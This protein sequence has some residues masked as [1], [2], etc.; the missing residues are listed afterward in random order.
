MASTLRF[1]VGP[2]F[3]CEASVMAW[4]G[5]E[6]VTLTCRLTANP[7]VDAKTVAWRFSRP[8]TN[9]TVEEITL[10]SRDTLNGAY[11]V[12]VT[13]RLYVFMPLS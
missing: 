5:D 7:P 3:E 11:L 6:N 9:D 8:A 12:T 10:S 13:V 1:S 2:R 4:P